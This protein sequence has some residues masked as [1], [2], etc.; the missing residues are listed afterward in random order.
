MLAG[1]RGGLVSEYFAEQLLPHVFA[2]RLGERERDAAR[3]VLSRLAVGASLLGPASSTRS[4][5]DMAAAPLVEMLGYRVVSVVPAADGARLVVTLEATDARVVM[6]VVPWAESLDAAWRAAVLE[7]LDRGASWCLVFNARELRILDSRHSYSRD[8]ATFDLGIV[9]GDAASFS[10]FWA[11]TR[12]LACERRADGASLLDAIVAQSARHAVRVCSSLRHGVLDALLALMQGFAGRG[13]RFAAGRPEAGMPDAAALFEQSLTVVYRM[14]FLLFAEARRLVPTWNNLYSVAYSM[15]MLRELAEQSEG[16]PRPGLWETFQAMSRLAHRGCRAGTL[17]VTP[18]NGRLF[19]PAR[20]PLAESGRL[21]DDA[22]RRAVVALSTTAAGKRAG[23]R[24]RIAYR[25][26]GV[27]ELGGVYESVLDY[28]PRVERHANRTDVVLVAGGG[29]RKATG[30]FYTPRSLTG[31]LVR[32][33]LHPLVE[34]R[35]ADD[36]LKLRVVDPAMGSGAFLVAACHYLS[37]AYESALV[38]EGRCHAGD[39]D[40]NDRA[41]FRRLVAQRCLFGVDLN[42]TAVQLARL[43]LWL[44]TLAADR[45]LTFL[46]HHLAVGDSLVGASPFDVLCAPD[47]HSKRANA[48]HPMLFDLDEMRG[49]VERALPARTFVE[50]APGDTLDAVREKERAI[51]SL[52]R[53]DSAYGRWKKAAD[54]WCACWFLD[55]RT[56]PPRGVYLE[57]LDAVLGR[58]TSAVAATLAPLLD[59][60]DSVA[61]LRRFF[62]WQMEFPEVFFDPSGVLRENGGFDA[63]I[64]NPPWDMLRADAMAPKDAHDYDRALFAFTRHSQ[65]YRDQSAG[66]PNRFQLF[67]E[68]AFQLARRK[69]RVG[70]VVPWGLLADHGCAALRRR[71][72]LRAN[73]DTIVSFDNSKAIFPIHRSLRFALL[74]ATTAAQTSATAC[75]LRETVATALDS[76]SGP[77]RAGDYPLTLSPA[78]LTRLSGADLAV[79]DMRTPRDLEILEHVSAGFPWISAEHGWGARFGRELNATD[80]R[81]QFLELSPLTGGPP[82]DALPVVEGKHL[83]PFS[84]SLDN[85]RFHMSPA[86]ARRLVGAAVGRA[87]LAYRDVASAT[88]RVTLIAAMLPAGCVSTHTVFCLATPLEEQAQWFLCGVMNS[89]VANY[90]V[91]M[92][93]TTHVS[94]SIVQ[95][96]PV[97]FEPPTWG[98]PRGRVRRSGPGVLSRGPGA[99]EHMPPRKPQTQAER[100]LEVARLA[101]RMASGADETTGDRLQAVVARLYRLTGDQFA[102]VLGTFPLVERS[103]RDAALELF[104]QAGSER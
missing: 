90:L 95:R 22:A 74:T 81:P 83:S 12:A 23:G 19:S 8:H 91:R 24:A 42:P 32:R 102:H 71:L 73:T 80:D 87:R 5:F 89:Y 21:P 55:G 9:A 47:R 40:E 28:E 75:R 99:T 39:I 16:G 93:V 36:I 63:V 69:G 7:G 31:Y 15:E 4:I 27:E 14:L 38:A 72:F 46:D 45:P 68:R 86:V 34:R 56:S 67:V 98:D 101:R 50:Q 94:A 64:G 78:L 6:I 104:E 52:A 30:T 57:A 96:L 18:F 59:R 10:V 29:K 62:H 61:R 77:S 35:A 70:L 26:L 33:T 25:D 76:L 66:H 43:S 48:A 2:G 82:C 60:A 58:T 1:I 49:D 103:R 100:S 13:R 53:P 20:T 85:V 11:L 17:V 3:P 79:P 41:A 44:A 65:H 97:P 37:A 51:E 84:V 88:N 92:R 54:L